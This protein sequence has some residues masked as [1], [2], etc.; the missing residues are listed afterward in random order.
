MFTFT[1]EHNIGEQVRFLD[2]RKA[3]SPEVQGALISVTFNVAG[4]SYVSELEDGDQI[5]ITDANILA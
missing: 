5:Y 2:Y 4:N 1:S 3:G